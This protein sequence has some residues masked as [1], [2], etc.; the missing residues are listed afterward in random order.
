M[1]VP[2]T[3]EEFVLEFSV[4][5]SAFAACVTSPSVAG[6]VALLA[7]DELFWREVS[8]AVGSWVT[9]SRSC[10]VWLPFCRSPITLTTSAKLIGLAFVGTAT[11]SKRLAM[12]LTWR[13]M[14]LLMWLGN[15]LLKTLAV[16]C[17]V[18]HSKNSDSKTR[19]RQPAVVQAFVRRK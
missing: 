18:R 1:S 19:Q 5:A 9:R 3:N 12:V 13:K 16:Q 11:S 2:A 14:R 15:S 4:A 6:A 7:D 17:C 8:G 10:V